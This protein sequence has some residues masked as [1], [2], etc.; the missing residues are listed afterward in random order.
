M[1]THFSYPPPASVTLSVVSR[2]KCNNFF[3]AASS[4]VGKPSFPSGC[5]AAVFH[6]SV[7]HELHSSVHALDYLLVYTPSGHVVQYKLIP[8][9]GGD[10]AESNSGIGAA[11]VLTS[12]EELR[13]KVEPVQ[14]WDVCRRADWPEREENICG[15]TFDGQKTAELTVDTSDSEYLGKPLEKHHV[16]LANAEVLIN[17][18]RKPIW[19]NLEVIS[20]SQFPYDPYGHVFLLYWLTMA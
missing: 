8:S 2:I 18:G 17:S 19:Q 10:Q 11:S 16:Y 7:P 15:L 12:E 20:T 9:L 1:T 6:Q 4:I 14:C 5:L 3:H 13:V